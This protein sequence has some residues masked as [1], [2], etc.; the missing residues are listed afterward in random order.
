MT[1]LAAGEPFE[2]KPGRT[3]ED[4]LARVRAERPGGQTTAKD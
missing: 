1:A 3:L 2:M 4:F